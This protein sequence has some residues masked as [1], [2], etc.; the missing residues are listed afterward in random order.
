M[1]PDL[2]KYINAKFVRKVLNTIYFSKSQIHVF[3]IQMPVKWPLYP[4]LVAIIGGLFK[5]KKKLGKDSV[6]GKVATI[7]EWPLYP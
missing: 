6:P 3:R 5:L 2:H 7:S 1:S 4:R